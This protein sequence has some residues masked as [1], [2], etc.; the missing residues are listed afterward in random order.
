MSVSTGDP[1]AEP[2][3]FAGLVRL[4]PDAF[5]RALT[6]RGLGLSDFCRQTDP[7]TQRTTLYDALH[8]R[9]IRVDTLRRFL[10]ALR[11]HRPILEDGDLAEVGS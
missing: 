4:R 6:R 3:P 11:K 9:C 7:P 8:G 2:G 5:N 1:I 10:V